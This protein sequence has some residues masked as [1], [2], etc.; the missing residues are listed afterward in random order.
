MEKRREA[1]LGMPRLIR[2]WKKV[3]LPARIP[4]PPSNYSNKLDPRLGNATGP[5]SPNSLHGADEFLLFHCTACI[6]KCTTIS[7]QYIYTCPHIY[8]Q[9]VQLSP[10]TNDSRAL[11]SDWQQ[12]KAVKGVWS[13]TPC[14]HE[15]NLEKLGA[16][17]TSETIPVIRLRG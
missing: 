13:A 3:C 4:I 11:L 2:E 6:T 10:I 5:N 16:Y 14:L 15:Y 17:L 12:V 1:I 7:W 8:P 9:G